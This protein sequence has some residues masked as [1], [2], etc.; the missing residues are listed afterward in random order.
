MGATLS[1]AI[2]SVGCH[3][4]RSQGRAR[5]LWIA[6]GG[7]SIGL[8]LSALQLLQTRFL[9]SAAAIAYDMAKVAELVAISVLGATLVLY[10]VRRGSRWAWAV[11]G[12]A[13]TLLLGHLL[14]LEARGFT[15]PGS[16]L[17]D[18][19]VVSMITTA[20][21]ALLFLKMP[22]KPRETRTNG[23]HFFTTLR[24]LIPGTALWLLIAV[25]PFRFDTFR[26][27]N[28]PV[29]GGARYA[30]SVSSLER[31]EFV[32][33]AFVLLAFAITSVIFHG[34]LLDDAKEIASTEAQQRM[35]ATINEQRINRLQ[36]EA[37]TDEIR[38]RQKAE[39]RLRYLAFHD[40]LTKLPNRAH[41]M[42]SLETVLQQ[43]RTNEKASSALLYID[44]DN[45]K[46]I[47]DMLGHRAGDL[48]LIEVAERLQRIA[49]EHTSLARLQGDEFTL[50]I[51]APRGREQ[52]IRVAQRILSLVEEPFSLSG[53]LL[54]ITASIGICEVKPSLEEAVNILRDADIAMYRAKRQG[55]SCYVFYESCMHD[56]T[57][58]ALQ[59]KKELKA[60]VDRCEFELYY[61]PLV[62]MRDRSVYG[63][64][65]LIRW[66]H[67]KRGLVGPG[68]F[69]QLAEETGYIC[70]IG[71]W[72]LKQACIDYQR[73]QESSRD[74]LLLSLNVSSRQLD[75]PG[76]LAFVK[77][78]LEETKMEPR[79]LQLEIT[80]SVFL[81]DAIRIG[82]LF[83]DLRA[84][85][86]RIAFDDFGTGYSSLSYLERYPI[87]TLKIDQSF[88]QGMVRSSVNLDIVRVMIEIARVTGMQVSA[89]GVEEPEHA[90]VL[91]ELGCSVCQGY[92]YSRPLPMA[93]MLDVLRYG[94]K[95]KTEHLAATRT[96]AAIPVP[97][98]Q[99]V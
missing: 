84:L 93:A 64:E 75:E 51:D 57:M 72:V 42:E 52:I 76:F 32:V 1:L 16:A 19:L 10:C 30:L 63:M 47:N 22:P 80:E 53:D 59:A 4:V 83:R 78:V 3:L 56:E 92:L 86:L 79:C 37:L 29:L 69:I 40:T 77:S 12:L 97:R 82:T 87:D 65:A 95:M 62:R 11:L 33:L 27:A 41:L 91:L 35:A 8:G 71:S 43:A 13:G 26:P 66:N 55:G 14:A 25:L 50:L 2:T 36:T 96:F 88:V 90:R 45:F 60:A 31:A 7:C 73:L 39:S 17:I 21:A 18:Q 34:R 85:G 94:L 9:G 67:P 74:P 24:Q 70:A 68:A 6:S 98:H 15:V 99:L 44:I 5:L 89:E 23:T 28:S 38:E 20:V 48:L 61:Q 81:N 49:R 46:L 54:N 58:A